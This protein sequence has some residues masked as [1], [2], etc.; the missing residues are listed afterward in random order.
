MG[1]Y[2]KKI[3]RA[4]SVGCLQC[5]HYAAIRNNRG[6]V[7]QV[8]MAQLAEMPVTTNYKAPRALWETSNSASQGPVMLAVLLMT[9]L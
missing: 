7:L 8:L 1:V 6:I 9:S 5:F 2:S 3:Q 4:G